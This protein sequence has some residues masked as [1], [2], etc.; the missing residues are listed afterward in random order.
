MEIQQLK[1]QQET[2]TKELANITQELHLEQENS[3]KL[4]EELNSNIEKVINEAIPQLKME[5]ETKWSIARHEVDLSNNVLGTGEWGYVTEAKYRG[6]RVAAKCLNKDIAMNPQNQ[7]IFGKEMKLSARCNHRNLVDF[8]GAIPDHPAII[9]IELMHCTLRTALTKGTATVS[10]IHPISFDV[11]K[12]LRY[13]HGIQPDPLIYHDLSASNILLKAIGNGWIAKLSD[14]GSVHFA[15]KVKTIAP[16]CPL[17]TAPEVKQND[18][19]QQQ[20]VKIDVYSYGV[21]LIEMLTREMPT[22]SIEALVSQLQ[23]RWPFIVPLITNCTDTDPNQRPS[24]RKVIDK[25]D[26]ITIE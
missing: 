2:T 5:K 17:Y 11:D 21:L 10:H 9:V 4:Q 18:S 20:T 24:M 19:S 15:S 12:G 16:V 25:L 8:I 14:V 26:T 7:K 1:L 6:Q 22:G 13:L 23:S 3:K